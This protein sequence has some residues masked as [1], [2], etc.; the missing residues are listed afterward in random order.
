M[1]ENHFPDPT[2]QAPQAQGILR[3]PLEAPKPH[4]CGRTSMFQTVELVAETSHDARLHF[5]CMGFETS[6][7]EGFAGMR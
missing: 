4:I 6:F 7:V 5:L 1:P 2:W 3:R